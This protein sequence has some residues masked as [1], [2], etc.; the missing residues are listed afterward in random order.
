MVSFEATASM[1]RPAATKP[2]SGSS[3]ARPP[4]R[5]GHHLD[6]AA[7]IPGALDEAL[8]LQIRQVLVHR[9]ERRQA[10]APADFFEARRVAVLLDELVQV[11]ENFPL[12][13]RERKHQRLPGL[14]VG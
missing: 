2:S 14:V 13:F 10:E 5:V 6:R 3:T 7:A 12:P 1:G 8:F 4:V 11:V 9:G